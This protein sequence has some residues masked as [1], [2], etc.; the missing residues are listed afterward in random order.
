MIMAR[1]GSRC[2]KLRAHILE[3]ELEMA[4]DF[5]TSKPALSDRLLQVRPHLLSLPLETKCFMPE[6][7]GNKAA[8]TQHGLSQ[9][10][11]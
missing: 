4:P 5:E 9:E 3:V 8:K 7:V 1:H 6:T 10:L 11:I 2:P